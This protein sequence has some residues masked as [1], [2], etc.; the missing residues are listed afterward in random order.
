MKFLKENYALLKNLPKNV[1]ELA[2]TKYLKGEETSEIIKKYALTCLKEG[3]RNVVSSIFL[4]RAEQICGL[5][6]VDSSYYRTRVR[7]VDLNE[8]KVSRLYKPG[9]LANLLIKEKPRI[10]WEGDLLE[11]LGGTASGRE[12]LRSLARFKPEIA[13]LI[14]PP[15]SQ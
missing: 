5:T 12:A 15:N 7:V 1:A 3:L 14:P 8:L 10:R 2:V 9:E 11:V 6:V 13:V 4:N